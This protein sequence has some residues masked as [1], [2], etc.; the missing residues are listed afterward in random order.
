MGGCSARFVCV[1]EA[2]RKNEAI[3]RRGV[4]LLLQIVI[5]AECLS[6]LRFCDSADAISVP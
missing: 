6:T 1:V 2:R 4:L 5:G 3:N